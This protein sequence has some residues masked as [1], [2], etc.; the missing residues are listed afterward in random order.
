MPF[1]RSV[2][3]RDESAITNGDI[4]ENADITMDELQEIARLNQGTGPAPSP[5]IK[6]LHR[7]AALF[8]QSI[9]MLNS[10]RGSR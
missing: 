4:P 3:S 8:D 10:D 5:K 7:P 1:V 2:R 6:I 9:D